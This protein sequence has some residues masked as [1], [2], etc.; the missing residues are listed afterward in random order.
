VL[1]GAL[2][3]LFPC[4]VL[5]Q[6]IYDE[7]PNLDREGGGRCGCREQLAL[8]KA[9]LADARGTGA[10]RSLARAGLV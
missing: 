2:A 9:P 1:R 8:C 5:I 6:S 4:F 7:Q 3:I 10:L